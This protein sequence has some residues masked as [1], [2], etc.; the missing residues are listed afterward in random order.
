MCW[1]SP[2]FVYREFEQG[3]ENNLFE[4]ELRYLTEMSLFRIYKFLKLVIL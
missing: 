1:V 4:I 2:I 3:F